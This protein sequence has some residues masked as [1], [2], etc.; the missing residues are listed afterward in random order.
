MRLASVLLALAV[1]LDARAGAAG[2]AH[3]RAVGTTLTVVAGQ[4]FVQPP[5][6]FRFQLATDDQALP[7][8]SRVRTAADSWAVLTL[9]DGTTA[10]LDPASEVVLARADP[11]PGTPS[12]LLASVQLAAGR[13][14]GQ[15][16]SLLER[17]SSLEVLAGGIRAVAREGTFGCWL[18]ADGARG[19][20]A[21]A[22]GP[23]VVE[24]GEAEHLLAPGEEVI[25]PAGGA[26]S[27]PRPRASA[28]GRLAVWVQGAVAVR[29]VDARGLTVGF[30]PGAL[31][32]N[33]LVEAATSLPTVPDRWLQVRAPRGGRY[34]L[35]VEPEA[36]GPYLVRA[37]LERDGAELAD[38]E[39][40]A[41]ARLGE[42]LVADLVVE[43]GAA[44]PVDLRAT[45]L[46]PAE[47][48]PPGRFAY[49]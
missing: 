20:W 10:T 15:V 21:S 37:T 13:V 9:P 33:Q 25:V 39:W 24:L 27:P 43:E 16:S 47:A 38:H 7:V 12:G 26:L 23:L 22:G 5:G 17:G 18:G 34:T 45:A 31:V 3:A 48:P 1:L 8:G 14:W 4:V 35:V 41:E 42:V 28:P 32:V 29:V 46:R 11:T 2:R 40:M 6:A 19:C 36:T 44:G 49:P 30:A